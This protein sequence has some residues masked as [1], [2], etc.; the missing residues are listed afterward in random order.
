[1]FACNPVAAFWDRDIKGKCMNIQAIAYATSASAIIQDLML[2]VL[3]L[4]FISNLQM[5]WSRKITVGLMF[6]VGTF[7]CIAT[8]IRLHALLKYKVTLDPTWDYATVVIWTELELCAT[9]VCISLPSIRVLLVKILPRQ[10]KDWLTN[11]TRSYKRS[12][13]GN[14]PKPAMPGPW[15]QPS[16]WVK[17]PHKGDVKAGSV[18]SYKSG[19]SWLQITTT[20]APTSPHPFSSSAR[21]AAAFPWEQNTSISLWSRSSHRFRLSD[22]SKLFVSVDMTDV[23]TLDAESHVFWMYSLG[24][25]P[26]FIALAFLP[27]RL[28]L[29]VG[30]GANATLEGADFF[31]RVLEFI[32]DFGTL[33]CVSTRLGRFSMGEA[34][35]G[36]S[37]GTEG[38]PV[39]NSSCSGSLSPPVD[40]V[41]R[42]DLL[43]SELVPSCPFLTLTHVRIS[44]FP[45]SFC[46]RHLVNYW[47]RL[48]FQRHSTVIQ[49]VCDPSFWRHPEGPGSSEGYRWPRSLDRS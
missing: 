3:P 39:S 2:L 19:K 27:E 15:K 25:T 7:G 8:V 48:V 12:R 13:N 26:G 11:V 45:S 24:L 14:T 49:E 33:C 37:G 38:D 31:S 21:T 41:P 34:G 6:A 29:G 36:G 18:S 43:A 32:A 23:A 1:M 42:C 4:V 20:T 47:V 16:S 22:F 10:F 5:K 40:L 46:A 17:I 28:V 30:S 9:V 35:P 44:S